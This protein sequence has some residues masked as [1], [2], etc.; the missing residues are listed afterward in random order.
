VINSMGNFYQYA[1]IITVLFLSTNTYGKTT[2]RDHRSKS[3]VRDH[4]NESVVRDHRDDPKDLDGDGID[5]IFEQ[6]L[7]AIHAP[8]V[9][10]PPSNVDWTRP[11]N[12]DWYLKRV[13]L[14]YE[15]KGTCFKDDKLLNVGQV[16]QRNLI[17][18]TH[19]DK[20]MTFK[21]C[22][23]KGKKRNSKSSTR[24]FLQPADKYHKGA[25]P[26]QWKAY[27]HVKKSS[28]IKG[29]FDIQYW[30]FY[31]YNDAFASF[32][33]EGDWEHITISTNHKGEF[34]EA[35][36]AQ[37][38]YST[39]Y[40]HRQLRF[41]DRTHPIVYSADGSHASYARAA[42]YVIRST[43][44]KDHTYEGGPRWQTWKHFVNVG[45]AKKPLNNQYFIQYGG[46]WGEIGETKHT[47]GPTGPAA[48]KQWNRR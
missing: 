11:A 8:E 35:I 14:R 23:N 48:K 30:F 27:V 37:H 3:T 28:A 42:S 17:N 43:P 45:E 22:K 36:F 24:F 15:N 4:R 19:R 39:K 40:L 12:V 29:G 10:L 38:E 2:V 26:A 47:S 25:P 13:Q 18:A 20:S 9:R 34:V 1:F 21:G 44:V 31:A 46:L 16:N 7:A 5:D 33:Y 32:N 6:R 41:V